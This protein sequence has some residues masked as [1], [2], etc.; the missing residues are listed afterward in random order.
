MTLRCCDDS[1][2]S[3]EPIWPEEYTNV[4]TRILIEKRDANL[5]GRSLWDC[6]SLIDRF[7]SADG[8]VVWLGSAAVECSR[9]T[10]VSWYL[11][12]RPSFCCRGFWVATESW[13]LFSAPELASELRGESANGTEKGLHEA[14][15]IVGRL[16]VSLVEL[17]RI[18]KWEITQNQ[19][20]AA[21]SGSTWGH[22]ICQKVGF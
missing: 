15:K 9:K 17:F 5:C 3:L 14:T 1:S 11:Q 12:C 13:R 8:V 22:S 2:A 20:T 18:C 16:K 6:R 21:G 10:A 19:S 7:A 4:K